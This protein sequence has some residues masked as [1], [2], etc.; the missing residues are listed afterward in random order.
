MVKSQQKSFLKKKQREKIFLKKYH[1]KIIAKIVS[2]MF[3]FFMVTKNS[4]KYLAFFKFFIFFLFL[5]FSQFVFLSCLFF[6][7][8]DHLHAALFKMYWVGFRA[9]K[10]PSY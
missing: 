7:R 8:S 1:G 4:S 6:F 10:S 9:F 2:F 5:F 3:Q